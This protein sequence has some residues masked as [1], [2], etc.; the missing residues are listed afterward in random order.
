MGKRGACL[1]VSEEDEADEDDGV[2]RE[3]SHGGLGLGLS[4]CANLRRC[5]DVDG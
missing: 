2:K 4:F 5:C 1:R 3:R